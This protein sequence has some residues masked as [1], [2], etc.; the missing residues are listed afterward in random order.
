MSSPASDERR[1]RACTIAVVLAGL[2]TLALLAAIVTAAVLAL[3]DDDAVATDGSER[4]PKPSKLEPEQVGGQVV[5]GDR[6]QNTRFEVPNVDTGWT[7]NSADTQIYIPGDD[8]DGDGYGDDRVDVIGSAVFQNGWCTDEEGR[9]AN[10]G[11][12]GHENPEKGDDA[13][14]VSKQWATEWTR[15]ASYRDDH[16]RRSPS[17][18]VETEEFEL[19]DGS[20]AYLSRS[21]V[22]TNA[23]ERGKCD[24]PEV[25]VNALSLATG[26]YVA[27][28]IL[29]R[30]LW[31]DGAG[32]SEDVRDEILRTV[33]KEV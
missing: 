26:D 15:F 5:A 1:S 32:I 9:S 4:P 10:R 3:G 16:K 11:V 22:T 27:T 7:V 2:S 6:L 28:V 23:A 18:P 33:H 19:G 29:L 13:E 30:D 25:E 21:V 24:A 12:I 31:T 14:V 17:T 20:T 8:T